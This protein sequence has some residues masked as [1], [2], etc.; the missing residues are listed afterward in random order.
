MDRADASVELAFAWRGAR[1]LVVDAA[2]AGLDGRRDEILPP[3]ATPGG[4]E[5]PDARYVVEPRPAAWNG[6]LAGFRVVRDGAVRWL[7]SSL[8]AL[9]AWLRADIA[10]TLTGGGALAVRADAVLWRQRAIVI[11]GR[12]G[13]GTSRL[14]AALADLGATHGGASPVVIGADGRFR[15]HEGAPPLDVA[16]IVSTAFH[17]HAT[18]QPRRLHGARALLPLIDGAL[19]ADAAPGDLLR[20]VARAGSGLVALQG[21]RPDAAG[22]APHVLAALDDL[23]DDGWPAR[24]RAPAALLRA[25]R[26]LARHSPAAAEASRT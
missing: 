18:W 6:P 22:V 10:A 2:G 5:A 13:S 7:G 16:L 12:S 3:Q 17:P 14:A 26:A 20:R 1:L 11:T 9:L 8:D 4:T 23:L 24:R 21:P 15:P 19:T 25:Q